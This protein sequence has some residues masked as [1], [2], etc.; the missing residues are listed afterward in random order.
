MT[1]A[2]ILNIV[3]SAV[4]LM[5]VTGALAW[6]IATHYIDGVTRPS[7]GARLSLGAGLSLGARRRRWA[8]ARAR[9]VGRTVEN[10]V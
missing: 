1:T 7:L 6:S 4:V 10:R 3:L 5:V 2:L 9:F 8:T